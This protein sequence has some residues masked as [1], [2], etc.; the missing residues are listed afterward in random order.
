MYNVV[1]IGVNSTVTLNVMPQTTEHKL[2]VLFSQFGDVKINLPQ[3]RQ[4]DGLCYN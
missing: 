2:S 1:K 4:F 3:D